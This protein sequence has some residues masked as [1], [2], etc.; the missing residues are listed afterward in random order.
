ML[1]NLSGYATSTNIR[2]NKFNIATFTPS[3]RNVIAMAQF[4]RS[5]FALSK[6]LVSGI[7][8]IGCGLTNSCCLSVMAVLCVY[9]VYNDPE[10]LIVYESYLQDWICWSEKSSEWHNKSVGPLIMRIHIFEPK[11][12]MS[13][14]DLTACGK[15]QRWARAIP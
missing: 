5:V 9:R 8:C 2:H 12:Y 4:N 10:I 11:L 6:I 1:A 3:Q 14:Q 7:K 13:R 15:F